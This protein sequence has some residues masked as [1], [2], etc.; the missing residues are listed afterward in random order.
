MATP[1][2]AASAALIRQYY[3]DGFYPSGTKTAADS[4][5]PTGALLKATL[6]NS[7][8]PMRKYLTSTGSLVRGSTD[9]RHPLTGS[10][11][12]ERPRRSQATASYQT[13]PELLT[14]QHLFV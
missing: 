9:G 3:M 13:V 11:I 2:A 14:E 12:S 10:C 5:R 4:F 8:V 1:V 6:I 7:A